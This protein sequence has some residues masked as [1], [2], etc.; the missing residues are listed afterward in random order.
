MGRAGSVAYATEGSFLLKR[1]GALERATA[2]LELETSA[3][4]HFPLPSP[5]PR[6]EAAKVLLEPDLSSP[7]RIGRRAR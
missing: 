1:D 7:G 4:I 3:S 5:E 6:A 2:K